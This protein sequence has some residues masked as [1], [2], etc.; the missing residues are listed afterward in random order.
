MRKSIYY[1]ISALVI[2]GLVA[3]GL[4]YEKDSMEALD[5]A[6]LEEVTN[7]E[8][9]PTVDPKKNSNFHYDYGPRHYSLTKSEMESMTSFND[10]IGEEHAG[11]I[12]EYK[13]ISVTLLDDGEETDMRIEGS[14]GDLNQAQL[15]FIHKA[16]YSTDLLVWAHYIEKDPDSGIL[17]DS[18]W[19][20][21][22]TVV[23]ET[24]AEYSDGK[25]A[26]L[27]FLKSNPSGPTGDEDG[28]GRGRLYF[29]VGVDGII[30]EMELKSSCEIPEIDA[31]LMDRLNNLP[32]KWIPAKNAKGEAVE[33]TLVL[34]FGMMGC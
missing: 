10:I 9:G 24:Q 28:L 6:S 26:L 22:I 7:I 25:E 13:S 18:S 16:A 1:I 20:P 23:P 2:L 27:D 21:Y 14:G 30:S 33:Q 17:Q 8:E 15:D 32:A 5:T 4:F 12:V 31:A 29:T 3:F 19:T 11:R 34:S